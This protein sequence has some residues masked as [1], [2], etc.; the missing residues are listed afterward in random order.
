MVAA[1]QLESDKDFGSSWSLMVCS[2]HSPSSEA[3]EGLVSTI[4]GRG[5]GC[6]WEPRAAPL[7]PEL[8]QSSASGTA[9]CGSRYTLLKSTRGTSKSKSHRG[10][11]ESPRGHR[12]VDSSL[13]TWS[14]SRLSVLQMS[15]MGGPSPLLP[16]PSSSFLLPLP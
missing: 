9:G 11:K 16:E 4:L 5:G 1:A 15:A 3:G 13:R 6:R 12:A 8:V 7:A 2:P 10:P 14:S